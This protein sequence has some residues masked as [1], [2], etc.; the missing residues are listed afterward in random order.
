MP[1]GIAL[2]FILVDFAFSFHRKLANLIAETLFKL[3]QNCEVASRT[4]NSFCHFATSFCFLQCSD[5]RNLK[6]IVE[7]LSMFSSFHQWSKHKL[8]TKTCTRNVLNKVCFF[9]IHPT[10]CFYTYIENN[11][12]KNMVAGLH[13]Y[14]RSKCVFESTSLRVLV[15][16]NAASPSEILA[17]LVPLHFA[18]N[19]ASTFAAFFCRFHPQFSHW[20]LLRRRLRF[21]HLSSHP[22]SFRVS[23]LLLRIAS[24][25]ASAHKA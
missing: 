12:K 24:A 23:L 14:K 15:T 5:A 17:P 11:A 8:I 16:T 1:N 2:S 6:Y 25:S 7:Y 9:T 10:L 22:F 19:F 3:L 21:S 20:H 4:D 13:F 18:S